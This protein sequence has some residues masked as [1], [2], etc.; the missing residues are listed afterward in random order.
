MPSRDF[1]LAFSTFAN[2]EIAIAGPEALAIVTS[3]KPALEALVSL[4]EQGLSQANASVDD[5]RL[6]G[7]CT[8]PGSFTGLRIGVAFAKTL[9]QTKNIPIVGIS[10]YDLGAFYANKYPLVSVARG[11]PN[12]YY[13]KVMIS[14]YEP[15]TLVQGPREVIENAAAQAGTRSSPATIVGT[16]FLDL[17]PGDAA[18]A[19]AVLAKQA[20]QA[21]ENSHWT[22]I[23]ID[24]GQRPNAVVNWERRHGVQA[25][26]PPLSRRELPTE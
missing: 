22:N 8:G 13:A 2:P 16:D 25:E 24:Y 14:E 4:V 23:A 21:G 9:A 3:T 26:G 10:T 6:I 17:Q 18:K 12:Y 15:A 1:T 20:V 19:L 5:V 11:K 7:V